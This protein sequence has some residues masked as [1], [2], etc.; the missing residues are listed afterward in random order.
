MVGRDR[1]GAARAGTTQAP[2]G[3]T[4]APWKRGRTDSPA[5]APFRHHLPQGVASAGP[6]I[7]RG[8]RDRRRRSKA[9]DMVPD[10]D[11]VRPRGAAVR[12]GRLVRRPVRSQRGRS[13]RAVVFPQRR[14]HTVP[15]PLEA[16]LRRCRHAGW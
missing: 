9:M 12:L 3:P 4:G 11:A 13:P 15:E 7:L 2:G 14:A 6:G 8:G 10:W 16:L 1:Y 5:G